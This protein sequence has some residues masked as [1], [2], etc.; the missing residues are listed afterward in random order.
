MGYKQDPN[1]PSKLVPEVNIAAPTDIYPKTSWIPIYHAA[2]AAESTAYTECRSVWVGTGG[3]I[4]FTFASGITADLNNIDDGTLL[5]I[6]VT[7]WESAG[8][9]PADIVFLY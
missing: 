9:V 6:R 5:P 7:K 8:G 3:D 1:D 2:S 4:T